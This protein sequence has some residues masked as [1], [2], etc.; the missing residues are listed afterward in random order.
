[1]SRSNLMAQLLR[2]ARLAERSEQTGQ[3]SEEAIGQEGLRNASRRQ[4][5]KGAMAVTASAAV[6]T[7]APTALANI[8]GK[9]L[10]L[11]GSSKVA[12]VGAGLAGLS[13]ASELA[14]MGIQAKV[15]EAAERVG[16][17][18]LSLR[19]YFPGQVV[20][21]GGEF[22]NSSHHTMIGYAKQLGLELEDFSMFPGLSYYQFGG[23]MYSEAQV[24]EEYR[25]FAASIRQDLGA[26][27][28]PTA[29]RFNETDALYDFMSLDDYLILHGAGGL[30]RSVIGAAYMAEYGANIEELSAISFLRFIYSD[31][32]SKLAPFGVF[33]GEHFRVVE[34]NDRI[35]TGLA[36]RL[37][38]PVALGH[39]LLAM[40]KLSSGRFRLT[41]DFG[42]RSIQSDHDVVV[43]TLPFSVLRDVQLHASLE[44]PAWKHLAINNAGMG[45]HSKLMLGFKQ[46]YWYTRHGLNGTGYSDN[47]YIQS[48]WEANPSKSN[49]SR[50][51]LVGYTGGA[52][53]RNG[54][55]TTAQ[56]EARSFLSYLEGVLPGANEAVQLD[57]RGRLLAHTERWSN[58]PLSMGSHTCNRPG[59]FTTIAHNE[60]KAIGNL[61]FAGEH[62]SSF[63]EWQGFM[64]G[65]ATSGLRAAGEVYALVKAK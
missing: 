38:N 18:C 65:A 19:G 28:Y 52:R 53:V 16:G 5:A 15:F 7:L 59:Y 34:G 56:N 17:R 54:K 6:G 22:I 63:Y 10:E 43:M 61:L 4:F 24:A 32:R 51:V 41:F 60:A 55:R 31:K 25:S 64:E 62:T 46:P 8:G 14:R 2:I 35:A 49:D 26:L 23:R 37:P 30:L 40:R 1:M 57:A 3:N 50:A 29:D 12:V 9:I 13:C 36:G 27:S 48:T 11:G 20:E 58:N 21:R 45:D 44:L 39:K 42:G 33:G 47:A